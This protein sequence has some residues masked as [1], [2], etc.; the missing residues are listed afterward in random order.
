MHFKTNPSVQEKFDKYPDHVREKMNALRELVIETAQED[1]QIDTLEETLKWGEPSYVTK[2]G[3]TLRM[4]W[5]QKTP[6]Q[7]ALYFVC[8]SKLVSTFQ[9]IY[10]DLFQYEKTRAIL[11]PL[12]GDV[13]REELKACISK[14]LNYHKIKHLDLLGG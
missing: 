8:T 11:L 10:G 5:K 1:E 7:Y 12:N 13:P 14:T 9:F 6:D 2:H 4:D 3:S